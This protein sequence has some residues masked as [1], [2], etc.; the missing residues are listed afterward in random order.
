MTVKKLLPD[1]N[2]YQTL[3]LTAF[4]FI[5]LGYAGQY[6]LPGIHNY[7]F[8]I[9]GI[10][11]A[12]CPSLDKHLPAI[13]V[14]KLTVIMVPYTLGWYKLINQKI[15]HSNELLFCI[16]LIILAVILFW[17][18]YCFKLPCYFDD[19]IIPFKKPISLSMIPKK[20]L[21]LLTLVSITSIIYINIAG[22]LEYH[23][24]YAYIWLLLIVSI[25]LIFYL[26]DNSLNI[27][28]KNALKLTKYDII[29]L[30]ILIIP[31]LYYYT[32]DLTSW[33]YIFY[34]DEF[35]FLSYAQIVLNGQQANIFSFLGVYSE[36]PVFVTY[37]EAFFMLLLGNNIWGWRMAYVI[38]SIMVIYSNYFIARSIGNYFYGVISTIILAFSFYHIVFGAYHTQAF[39]F[40]LGFIMIALALL[41]YAIKK[42]S[43]F[44]LYV[45]GVTI[46]LSLYGH[47]IGRTGIILYLALIIIFIPYKKIFHYL[48]PAAIGFLSTFQFFGDNANLAVNTFKRTV[49]LKPPYGHFIDTDTGLYLIRLLE[50]IYVNI[51]NFIRALFYNPLS[52]HYVYGT[53]FDVITLSGFLLGFLILIKWCFN[54][55]K[56]A[57][58][59][60]VSFAVMFFITVILSDYSNTIMTKAAITRIYFL[61]PFFILIS[62]IGILA[63]SRSFS[64]NKK[65][66]NVILLIIISSIVVLNIFRLEVTY[67]NELNNTWDSTCL[68]AIDK[69]NNY[70]DFIIIFNDSEIHIMPVIIR[71]IER[72]KN[73]NV[74]FISLKKNTLGVVRDFTIG[75][76]NT[77]TDKVVI[78]TTT[79]DLPNDNYNLSSP[80]K[81]LAFKNND[82]IIK[83]YT[84]K[85]IHANNNH[86]YPGINVY[87][88]IILIK[89]ANKAHPPL[90]KAGFMSFLAEPNNS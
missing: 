82:S 20:Y 17:Y 14:L 41:F 35:A 32:K 71:N 11:Y 3:Y 42:Q 65:I 83:N 50:A 85:C 44:F 62:A 80:L 68:R 37:I 19:D 45:S 75:K 38:F 52:Y 16:I 86:F 77:N 61:I 2:Q 15:L 48:I 40:G 74:R 87:I 23:Y 79:N 36:H 56:A 29:F 57:V 30:I 73:H 27:K 5:A 31:V 8:I 43:F 6:V 88:P 12:L 34:G 66:Q 76:I 24:Y 89:P 22:K 33:K 84:L 67:A 51:I 60:M 70:K 55:N 26:I 49:F 53:L 7:I 4:A 13:D 21:Y 64:Q 1:Y 39:S 58:F 81:I 78:L 59:L 9:S 46:G 54:K 10:I 47:F 28:V 90:P 18:L 25:A 69:F 72:L 63:I